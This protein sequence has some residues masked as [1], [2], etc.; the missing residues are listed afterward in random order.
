VWAGPAFTVLF[1]IGFWPIAGLCPPPPPSMPPAELAAQLT[2]TPV[3]IGLQLCMVASAFFFPFTAIMSV[4][5]KRI[6][7][8]YS[9][10]A[11][12]Q[13]AAGCGSTLV[14]LF[15]LMSMQSAAYRADR[16]PQLV[17]AISDMAWIPFVGLLC[18][19]AMQNVCLAVAILTDRSPAPVFPRWA[20]YLNVWVGAA[21]LPA[22]LLVFVQGG[23]VA[24]NGIFS[25]WLGAFAFFA[26]ILAMT[27][28]LLRAV[29]QLDAAPAPVVET[30]SPG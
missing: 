13:L 14:F 30:R 19:P 11:Y 8:E 20:G 26:W 6:E 29:R 25:W 12:A 15:P 18:V 27:P 10:L 28:L 21:Y 16:D 2:A 5:I 3:K 4:Q 22:V 17:Q 7:G 23:P 24:W 9:P 1:A